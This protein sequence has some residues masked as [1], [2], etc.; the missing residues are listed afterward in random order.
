MK[1]FTPVVLL[2]AIALVGCG[3]SADTS[4]QNVVADGASED[5][6]VELLF[7]QD[8]GSMSYDGQTLTFKDPDPYTLYFSDRP[9]R[10]AGHIEYALEIT[11][12]K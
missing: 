7:V 8:A 12:H 5:G 4:D 2:I 9:D 10:I 11:I 3:Q 1:R 6:I